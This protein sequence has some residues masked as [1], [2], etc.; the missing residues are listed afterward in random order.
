MSLFSALPMHEP[1]LKIP[2]YF[3]TIDSTILKLRRPPSVGYLSMHIPKGVSKAPLKKCLRMSNL[4]NEMCPPP[5]RKKH[6]S[7]T[8]LSALAIVLERE[9][10]NPVATVCG[11]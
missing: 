3:S 2:A 9:P 8:A 5:P 7:K 10:W 6:I 11:S 4:L 1:Q